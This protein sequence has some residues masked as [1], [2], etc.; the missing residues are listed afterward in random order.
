MFAVD[1]KP[2]SRT[3]TDPKPKIIKDP[4]V[5]KMGGWGDASD[6]ILCHQLLVT[7]LG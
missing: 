7:R 2:I 6:D 1:L 3:T 5:Y 4:F